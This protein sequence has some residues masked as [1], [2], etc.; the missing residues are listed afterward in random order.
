MAPGNNRV[1]A[2]SS[3]IFKYVRI[4]P[5]FASRPVL[6]ENMFL[7]CFF[8]KNQG[9][10]TW[11]TGTKAYPHLPPSVPPNDVQ[12]IWTDPGLG[13]YSHYII[14]WLE[15]L[16]K[17]LRLTW[18][19]MNHHVRDAEGLAYSRNLQEPHLA[20]GEN[21]RSDPVR[22][23][24]LKMNQ[25]KLIKFTP[26][27]NWG[28]KLL[29]KNKRQKHPT[30]PNTLQLFQTQ[31][32]NSHT[33]LQVACPCN[34]PFTVL[35]LGHNPQGKATLSWEVYTHIA[36]SPLPGLILLTAANCVF[37]GIIIRAIILRGK[38]Y[39]QLRG[40]HPYSQLSPPRTNSAYS[41]KLRR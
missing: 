17:I 4:H 25:T 11:Q 14:T 32:G 5:N 33:H 10:K 20:D 21:V 12:G 22:E 19:V 7:C 13:H 18:C 27:T 41:W 31:R 35:I 40:V 2:I 24:S 23:D 29:Q 9:E 16:P 15:V 6:S 37:N 36:S 34:H 39:P 1:S 3:E 30:V 8:P 26:W 38:S 28:I